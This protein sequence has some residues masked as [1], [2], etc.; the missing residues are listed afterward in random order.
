M[1]LGVT[2]DLAGGSLKNFCLHPFG[3]PQHVDGPMHT[4]L[5]GLDR[6]KLIV[7]GGGR[8]GQI[9]NFVHLHKQGKGDIVAH[10]FKMGVA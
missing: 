7:D 5:G 8:T 9:I 2:I 3:Q 1:D 6:I 4:G 10:Q